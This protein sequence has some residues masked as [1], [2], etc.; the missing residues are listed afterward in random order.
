[1][2][3][4]STCFDEEEVTVSRGCWSRGGGAPWGTIDPC[5]FVRWV[6]DTIGFKLWQGHG[7]IQPNL[8]TTIDRNFLGWYYNGDQWWLVVVNRGSWPMRNTFDPQL[9]PT[10]PF[11]QYPHWPS[12]PRINH[13]FNYMSYMA[14]ITTWITTYLPL[15]DLG[16]EAMAE[17]ITQGLLHPCGGPIFQLLIS[18]TAVAWTMIE[19]VART[20]RMKLWEAVSYWMGILFLQMILIVYFLWLEAHSQCDCC[21]T[22]F[23]D[24]RN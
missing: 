11:K 1:M 14:S 6:M 18:K 7:F 20:T 16:L 9:W 5:G 22:N 17:E 24:G 23:S 3:W 10:Y 12:W 19:I 21:Y 15:L 2:T 13:H 4:P 8:Q